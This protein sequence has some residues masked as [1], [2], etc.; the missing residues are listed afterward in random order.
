VGWKTIEKGFSVVGGMC[1]RCEGTG[2]VTDTD[3]TQ[4]Y[5]DARSLAEGAVTVPGWK[6]EGWVVQSFIESG[7]FDPHK[8]IRDYTA[9]EMHDLL[10][11]EPVKVKVINTTC[12][13]LLARVRNSF[14]QGQGEPAAA[15][16][17]I[18]GPDGDVRDLP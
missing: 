11:R 10:H 13:G 14:L 12:E 3:P 7:F 8:A 16:P 2:V 5:D 18:R 17:G 6:P 1:L 9:Q 15:H 4:L